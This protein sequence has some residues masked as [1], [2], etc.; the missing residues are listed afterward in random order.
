ATDKDAYLK[1][2]RS[3]RRRL[4]SDGRFGEI[5]R[6]LPGVFACGFDAKSV[7]FA[8]VMLTGPLGARLWERLSASR[9]SSAGSARRPPRG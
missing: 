6:R 1:A 8:A 7:V 5:Y 3:R 9:A 4:G 2:F